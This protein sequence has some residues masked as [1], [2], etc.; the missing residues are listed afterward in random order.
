MDQATKAKPERKKFE[1][2]EAE[3][4]PLSKKGQ[5]QATIKLRGATRDVHIRNSVP[6]DK[7]AI[8]V[9]ARRMR[10]KLTVDPLEIL[11][12]SPH[13]V[14]P[15][16]PHVGH[17]GGC[18]WQMMDYTY[19]LD[20]K[21]DLIN[22][23]F[24]PFVD[25]AV[26][27]PVMPAKELFAYRNKVEYTFSQDREGAQ[28]L[29]FNQ[30]GRREKVIEVA[31]CHLAPKWMSDIL[32]AVR[33]WWAEH[34]SIE[35]Y[36][37]AS[38]RGC[39]RT[40]ICREGRHTGE[41]MVILTI[42]E[43][44]NYMLTGEQIN[45]FK[46]YLLEYFGGAKGIGIFL[47]IHSV[48][49][50]RGDEFYEMHLHG[51]ATVK[52]KLTVRDRTFTFDVSPSAFFQPNTTMAQSIYETVLDFAAPSKAD[53]VLD[54]YAGAASFGIIFAPYVEKV[55]SIEINPYAVCDG[56]INIENNEIENLSIMKG[57]V[58]ELL[59]YC[60]K[61]PDLVIV[62]PPRAGLSAAACEHLVRLKPKKIVYVACNPYTQA[63]NM[64]WLCK[65]NYQITRIKPVDQFP[66]TPH[67][68]NIILLEQSL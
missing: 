3:V 57:D 31:Q 48:K 23:L 9:P 67:V 28:Y 56:E 50:N 35:A 55:L 41:K 66:Q 6:G 39:L 32:E 38:G 24:T 10:R 68:E 65:Q 16:C 29:G 61:V 14:T 34:R 46:A 58:G 60:H 40:L 37:F 2:V 47:R 30:P 4:G 52:E 20:Q 36:H 64:E 42:S 8:H 22:H 12:P 13:R 11:S 5:G 17:C 19:Q 33:A 51:V 53:Y 62:D 21:Q 26:I 49:K 59:E 45:T 54:L 27:E 1:R 43:E 63:E 44:V 15:V 18:G 7:L 25:A